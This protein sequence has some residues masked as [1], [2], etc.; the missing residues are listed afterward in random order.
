M[1][2]VQR[3]LSRRALQTGRPSDDTGCVRARPTLNRSSRSGLGTGPLWA[4]LL[5]LVLVP[6]VV[7]GALSWRLA[8][9]Q[10]RQ[11]RESARI[12]SLVRVTE[13]AGDLANQVI[14]EEYVRYSEMELPK[15]TNL[16]LITPI[17]RQQVRLAVGGLNGEMRNVLH[18][19]VLRP[20]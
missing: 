6:L 15:V 11:E 4:R 20:L 7:V 5:A 13:V 10:L 16:P 3:H 18:D 12:E 17:L 2:E 14:F 19:K 9:A 1:R 8:S